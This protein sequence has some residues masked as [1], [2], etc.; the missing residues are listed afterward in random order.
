VIDV[1]TLVDGARLRLVTMK[2]FDPEDG[3]L[4]DGAEGEAENEE[5]P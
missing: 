1:A 5:S 2:R 3:Q 4:V